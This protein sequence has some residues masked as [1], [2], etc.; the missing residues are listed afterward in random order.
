V[1]L[2][3]IA[4]KIYNITKS[5]SKTLLAAAELAVKIVGKGHIQVQDRDLDFPS[6]GALNIDAARRDFGFDPKIDIDEGF[7]RYYEWLDN[8][9]Y[10]SQKT[11]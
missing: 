1:T 2:G 11:V 7:Q 6:R 8:S 3:N 9:V 5:H 4:N 10:W